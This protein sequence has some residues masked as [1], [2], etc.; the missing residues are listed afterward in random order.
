MA[1]PGKLALV[2]DLAGSVL[3]KC[4]LPAAVGLT[5]HQHQKLQ[6]LAGADSPTMA[7]LKKACRNAWNAGRPPIQFLLNLSLYTA[8]YFRLVDASG[9]DDKIRPLSI[10]RP[11]CRNRMDCSQGRLA[12]LLQPRYGFAARLN[13]TCRKMASSPGFCLACQLFFFYHRKR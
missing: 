4:H 12:L 5:A 2:D 1:N 6:Q 10:R 13:L 11:I 3:Q 8:G 7:I 9:P